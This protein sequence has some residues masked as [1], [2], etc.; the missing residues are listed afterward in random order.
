VPEP[1]KQ[2][3]ELTRTNMTLSEV[4]SNSLIE[5]KGVMSVELT[6]GTKTFVVAIFVTKVEGNYSVIG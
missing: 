1:R 6:I 4:G 5:T 2:D 3:N